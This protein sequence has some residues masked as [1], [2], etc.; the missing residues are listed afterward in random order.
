MRAA[1]CYEF[2]QPLVIDEVELDEPARGEVRVK[3]KAVAICH[4]DVHLIRG[5]WGGALPVVAGHEA[6]GIVEAVG[7][8]VDT[9]QPGDHVIVSLL[10]SCG[11]CFYCTT[12]SPYVCEGTFALRTETRLHLPSG[13]PV[14]QGISCGAFAEYAVVDQSQLVPVPHDLPF[15]SLAL[16]ACGVITGAGAV[17]NTGGV[18]PGESVAVIGSG[19]VGLNAVQGAALAGANPIIALDLLES[20]LEAARTFGA[21]HTVNAADP[22]LLARVRALTGERGPDYAVVTVGSVAAI[23]QALRLARREGTVVIAG[24]PHI[25]ASYALP[26]FRFVGSGRRIVGSVMGS[27]RLHVD[28]PRFVDLYQQ[29]R[30]KLDQLISNRYPLEGINEAIES[31][32]SGR[33]LRNVI[34]L[35]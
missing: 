32:E 21:T 3:I 22:E 34:M 8:G 28:V 2:G 31:M 9:V 7:E 33:A 30:L 17:I 23:E 26:V 25:D 15:D 18:R 19:G 10:R 6:S 24:M 16:L 11:H 12:G 20:K 4:S 29:G 1:V 13:E 14:I 5:E 35:D 27:T